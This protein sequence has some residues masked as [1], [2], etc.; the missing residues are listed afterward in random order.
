MNTP[1][2]VA[3]TL[4]FAAV[5]AGGVLGVVRVA[6]RERAD[7]ARCGKDLVAVGP[8]CCAPGQAV[9]RRHCAGRPATCPLGMHLGEAAD[10]CVADRSRVAFRGGHL[11]LG[12]PDWQLDGVP[13]REASVTPFLLDAT[14]V[15]VERWAHCVQAGACRAI[16]DIE[17]GIPV[18]GVDPKEAEHFCRF[19]GGRLPHSD[20][21][22][23]AA[24]GTE[25]RRFPWGP[26]G[27]VCRR[28]AFGLEGGPCA[29]NGGPELAGSRPD[30]ATPNG[31]LD[32]AGNV[33]E[34]TAETDGTF[35]A[36]GGSYRSQAAAELES[37]SASTAFR[38]R[39]TG[40]RCAYDK[41]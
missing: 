4:A 5:A 3:L 10:G 24:A 15:T 2:V 25:G 35:I 6:T 22:V 12:A 38:S 31:V 27:L 14:E 37:W 19:E 1:R 13:G 20:E 34:W 16:D 32:L 26:T 36:R 17:P 28:A 8:R 39:D 40:F 23:F 11:T 9:V 7:P 18:T 41:P 21:W 29:Q 30:G 33:A